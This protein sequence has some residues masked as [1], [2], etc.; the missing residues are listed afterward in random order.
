V[1]PLAAIFGCHGLALTDAERAFFRACDPFGFILFQRNCQDRDQVRRLTDELRGLTGRANCPILIDQEG[2]RVQRLKPPVWRRYPPLR[3][4]AEVWARDRDRAVRGAWAH[5]RAIALDLRE[6]GVTV[7]CAPVLDFS[8]PGAHEVIGD[9]SF[10]DDVETIAALGQAQLDGHLDGGVLPVVKHCPGHGRALAD[11]HF[12]LPV[13]SQP[14]G[15]LEATDFAAF[16]RLSHAPFAMTAHVVFSALDPGAPATI[17]AP[18]IS[19]IVRGSVGFDGCLLTDDLSMKALRGGLGERAQA[20]LA[21]GCDVALHCNGD[22]A[23]MEQ[24]ARAAPRL[25]GDAWRRAEAA[26]A[27]AKPPRPVDREALEALLSGVAEAVA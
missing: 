20:A 19:R 26:L 24:V 3:R 7:N 16:R 17:S 9:R 4:W 6:I 1:T 10:G 27:Q 12:G 14:L 18:V 8:P 15:V 2:G 5:A 22:S 21:A 23:E 25:A 13:V 11:S